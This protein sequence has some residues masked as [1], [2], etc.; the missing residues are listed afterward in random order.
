MNSKF[1]SFLVYIVI[2]SCSTIIAQNNIATLPNGSKVILHADKTWEYHETVSYDYDFS[3]IEE[4]QIPSILRQGISADKNTITTAVKMYLQG[5]KYSMPRPKSSQASWGNGDGR[6][7]WWKGYWY[8]GKTNKYSQITPKAKTNG[9]YYGDD[10]KNK[11]YWG[12][13]GSPRNPSKIEWLLSSFGG[14]KPY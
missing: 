11:G 5:W 1:I 8:N 6:T 14:V 4:N 9:F 2:S 13:G 12:N 7:T 3:K 10:Q